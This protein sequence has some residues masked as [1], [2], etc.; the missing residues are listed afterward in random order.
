MLVKI[1]ADFE[2]SC[3]TYESK[4]HLPSVGDPDPHYCDILTDPDLNLIHPEFQYCGAATFW[5]ALD[6]QGPRANPGS[7]QWGSA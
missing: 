1:K 4:S 3:F 2:C 7:G 6:V 5:A